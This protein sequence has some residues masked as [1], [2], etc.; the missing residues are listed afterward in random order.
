MKPFAESCEQNKLPILQVLRTEFSNATRILEIG[1]GTGQHAVF[2]AAQLPHLEWQTSDVRDYH[3]GIGAWID[4][5]RLPNVRPPLDLDV[6]DAWPRASYDGVFSANTV[7]IMGW[8]EVEAMFAGVGS[9][10]EPGGRFCLYGPFNYGGKFTSDSNARFDEWLKARD[11]RSGVRDFE[12]LDR[13]AQA[14][15]MELINDYA[16]P[17]NNR[18]LVWR[19]RDR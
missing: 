18:I 13:L 12:V 7:H 17:A 5:A 14:A 8:P 10:L 6:R 4:E 9:V 3:P 16:M 15:G 1:S 19:T 11:A 2:F